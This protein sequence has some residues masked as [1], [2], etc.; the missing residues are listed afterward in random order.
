MRFFF[1]TQG[2]KA[3]VKSID[4]YSISVAGQRGLKEFQY[5]QV[6]ME[7]STQERI[8]EDTNVSFIKYSVFCDINRRLKVVNFFFFIIVFDLITSHNPIST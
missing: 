4:E 8:F 2:N 6:F 1:L 5:D 3:V 7:D